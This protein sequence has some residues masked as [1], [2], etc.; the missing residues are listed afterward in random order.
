MRSIRPLLLASA[1]VTLLLVGCGDSGSNA[2]KT[3]TVV[4]TAAAP[5]PTV[6]AIDVRADKALARSALLELSDFPVGWTAAPNRD[7]TQIDCAAFNEVRAM[8]RG[9]SPD[10]AHGDEEFGSQAVAVYS[11]PEDVDKA[12]TKLMSPATL[13][14][15]A[16]DLKDSMVENVEDG[17]SIGDVTTAQLNVEPLGQRSAAI[18]VQVPISA[19]GVNADLY[20]D[21]VFSQVDRGLTMLS[22]GSTYTEPD[23][24][25]RAT[26]TRRAVQRLSDALNRS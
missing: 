26:L 7:P 5:A 19:G 17:A 18:R 20:A 1:T 21:Y 16:S 22:V 6:P 11:A 4:E 3:V 23:D 14:C 2:S 10:F 13:D 12:I 15:L 25:L 9:E 8:P 24:E